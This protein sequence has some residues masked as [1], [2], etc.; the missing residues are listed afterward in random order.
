MQ[1]AKLGL[2][3]NEISR[4]PPDVANFMNLVELDIRNNG[5]TKHLS[6]FFFLPEEFSVEVAMLVYYSS[7]AW[8]AGRYKYVHICTYLAMA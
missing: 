3:D 8:Q 6:S 2:S 7:R 5:K 1:L 4:L